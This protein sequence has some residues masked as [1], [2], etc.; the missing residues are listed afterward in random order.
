MKAALAVTLLLL[1]LALAACGNDDAGITLTEPPPAGPDASATGVESTDLATKPSIEVPG[2]PPPKSLETRDIVAGD[3]RVA[4]AGDTLT[5]QYV[6]V[7]YKTGEE[8]DSSWK[9]GEPFTFQ[10]GAGMVIPGWDQ[11]LEGMKVGGRR[12]LT[13][14]PDL[15]YGAQG[16]PP[17]IGPDETLVF[18]IDLVNAQ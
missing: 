7:S 8:F 5:V 12:E 10:L 6:G 9:A 18:V 15:A 13:I 4:A 14:P 16:S 11:G 17:A 3:G 1:G 2:G